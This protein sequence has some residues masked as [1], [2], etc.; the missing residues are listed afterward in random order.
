MSASTD[1][2]GRVSEFG[3]AVADG[4][5]RERFGLLGALGLILLAFGP[6]F[7][8]YLFTDFLVV[9]LFALGFNLLYGYTGLLS[10]G[11]GLFY[12][13]GAYGVAI[14]LRD[15]G[16]VF[17]DLVG[18][19]I[20]PLVTFVVGGVVGLALVVVVAVPVG[21]LSV[22]LEEIYFALITLAFGM[23]GYSLIIQDPAGLT[24]GTDGSSSCS[25]ASTSVAGASGSAPDGRTTPS[26]WSS[27]SPRRT[28]R[29]ASSTHRS[30][31]S[32]RRSARAPTGRRR[33][34]STSDTT[35][36]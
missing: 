2:G 30:A 15:L 27:C 23:L 7:Q 1:T 19:G 4:W 31:P 12:A 11:H 36:G 35:A 6:S 22:R 29:G 9:A 32:V 16:P 14:V 5:T 21:W 17:A 26:P 13:G 18:S 33:S 8:I 34:G 24:N 25:G 20:S 28:E 3:S 10:F